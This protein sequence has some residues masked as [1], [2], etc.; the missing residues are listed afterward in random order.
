MGQSKKTLITKY[1]DAVERGLPQPKFCTGIEEIDWHD[2]SRRVRASDANFICSIIDMLYQGHVL[3]LRSAISDADVQYIKD[4]AWEFGVRNP[5]TFH[6][7]IE[8]CPDFHRINSLQIARDA[9]YSFYRAQHLFYFYRW[10]S[11]DAK[12][13]KI[14]DN[15]WEVFKILCGWSEDEFKKT[16]PRDGLVD[17]LHIHHYA[18]GT[19]E[20]ESHQDPYLAQKMIMGHLLSKKGVDG[21]YQQGGIYYVSEAGEQ[22]DV[23]SMLKVG[24]AYIS[25][26]TLIHGVAKCD[27]EFQT[28][29]TSRVGRWFMGFYTLYSDHVKNRHTGWA[30]KVDQLS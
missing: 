2:F 14:A 30:V 1:W 7:V 11:A 26:P 13:F 27:P 10:N 22:I 18:S 24:D 12:L 3:I 23:D 6:R 16:T 20:Q 15:T 4:F 19:G 21:E 28:D 25:F 29:W 17:R 8:G 9:G 5:P